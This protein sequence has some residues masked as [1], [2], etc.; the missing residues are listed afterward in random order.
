MPVGVSI[1]GYGR[2]APEN[3]D[4]GFSNKS[5]T[6]FTQMLGPQT[7]R[8]VSKTYKTFGMNPKLLH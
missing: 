2:A 6:S 5:Q 8:T 1:S 4:F 7:I 3:L